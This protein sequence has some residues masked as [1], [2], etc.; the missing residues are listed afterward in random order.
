[1]T[2]ETSN[3]KSFSAGTQLGW[4]FAFTQSSGPESCESYVM[5][6]LFV[7][8]SFSLILF[9]QCLSKFC[10]RNPT[11]PHRDGVDHS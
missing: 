8:E 9:L 4:D 10:Q 2:R 11:G 1:M 3:S 5:C 6:V 7:R